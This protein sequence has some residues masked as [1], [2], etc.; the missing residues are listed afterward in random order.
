VVRDAGE[1]ALGMFEFT[2]LGV[3]FLVVGLLYVL[4][5]ARIMLPARADIG[6]LT[7]KYRVGG[8]LT[9]LIL[10]P[11]STLV[12]QTVSETRINQ[13]YGV[14]VLEVIRGPDETHLEDVASVTLHSDDHLIVQGALE[15]I[16]RLRRDHGLALLPDV[17]LEDEELT[18]GGQALVEAWVAPGSQMI[19]RTLKQLDFHHH[20]G[21]FV[22]AIRRVATTLRKRVADVR[23]RFADALLILVPRDRIDEL[24]QSGDLAVLSEHEVH[25]RR[26][27]MWWL[28]LVVLPLVV[29]TAASGAM[30][31][32]GSALVGA[33]V[34]LLARVVT[35]EEAYRAINWPVVFMIAA[36]VPLG[37]AFQVTGTAE[38]LAG[39]LLRV[40]SWASVDLAP[41]VVLSAV[42]VA[43]SLLTQL[44]S[45]NAAA[46]VVTPI[47]LSLG[48]ALGV[49][50][51]PFVFAV[52]FAASAA[53]M[54]PMGYQTNLMV[55]TAGEYRF[56]DYVRFGAP[57]NILLWL[58]A[59]VLIPLFW[60]F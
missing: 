25:L 29:A 40:S 46:I 58:L 33:V 21:A 9:E 11:E 32:A 16:L 20:H 26:G 13:R 1:K 35:P 8:Y 7:T 59:T 36:F 51:R 47:A 28:V 34:L 44:A 2:T 38:F 50:S 30:D 27:R 54:T 56:V 41:Y 39:G 24:E 17:H 4:L 57:L 42:Y 6:G 22:L 12:G 53:F 3:V 23:L 43:T 14:T 15:D 10:E 49:D 45:N 31:I 37:Y 52:C 19:G 48:P 5:T 55:Y 60:P 18:A